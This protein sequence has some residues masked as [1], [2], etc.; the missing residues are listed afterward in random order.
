MCDSY[1][2]LTTW[3]PIAGVM[4]G[5]LGVIIAI[6]SLR[7]QIKRSKFT[8]SVDLLLK[9]E[10]RFTSSQQMVSAR[11]NA[12]KS[13]QKGGDSE[14]DDVFDFFETVG[15]LV[16]KKALDEEMVWNTFFYWLHHYW[17]AS[18]N[19]VASQRADDPTT[20]EEFAFLNH[21][22]TQVEKRKTHCS[23]DDLKLSKEDIASFLEEES[24]L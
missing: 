11:R 24:Q 18:E 14:A 19:Y 10:D 3:T 13:L 5:L 20:W 21:C 6:L 1:S 7:S 8:Q 23:D 2:I 16:R 12:A 15:M 4:V 9:L 22:I 17:V